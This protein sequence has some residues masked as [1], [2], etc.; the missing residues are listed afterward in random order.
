MEIGRV[1]IIIYMSMM[2]SQI[3]MS[4]E[5]HLEAVLHVFAFLRKNYNSR[6]VFYPTYTVINMNEFKE[7]KW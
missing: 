1:D 2:A 7:C 4:R 6:I 3:A 5:V